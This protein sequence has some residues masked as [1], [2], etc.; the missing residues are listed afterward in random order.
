MLNTD[1]LGQEGLNEDSLKHYSLRSIDDYTTFVHD[2]DST[3]LTTPVVRGMGNDG[4]NLNTD[5]SDLRQEGIEL[6]S[7]RVRSP[8]GTQAKHST[9]RSRQSKSHIRQRWSQWVFNA[10]IFELLSL[11]VSAVCLLGIVLTLSLHTNHPLPRW[12]F[13]I[14]INAL[15][16]ALATISKSALLVSVTAAI[17]Q[18]KWARHLNG[19]NRQYDLEIYDEASRGPWGSVS[20]LLSSGWRYISQY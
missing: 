16:S 17:S 7:M 1:G 13:S 19:D 10:W 20:L 12:P 9:V 18:R 3:P 8:L 6:L 2:A 4:S 14:T 15:I 5:P 11:L